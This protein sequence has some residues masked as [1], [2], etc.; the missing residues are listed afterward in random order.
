MTFNEFTNLKPGD[1]LEIDEKGYTCLG[2]TDL[3]HGT[4]L[5]SKKKQHTISWS[6]NRVFIQGNGSTG[7]DPAQIKIKTA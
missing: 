2:M 7:H 5:D 4:F 6:E 1:V 3:T